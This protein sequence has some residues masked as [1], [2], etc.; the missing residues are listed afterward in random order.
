M[1]RSDAFRARPNTFL[2]TSSR[3][4][5][6]FTNEGAVFKSVRYR[7][8]EFLSKKNPHFT[9]AFEHITHHKLLGSV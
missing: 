5:I 9:V 4:K 2:N 7:S 3:L 6:L 1:N 8:A